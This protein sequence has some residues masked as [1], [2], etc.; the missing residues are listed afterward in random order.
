MSKLKDISSIK[1]ELMSP[2]RI[3]ELSHGE[4][5]KPE[6]I[7]YRT[8]KPERDGLFCE[9]IFGTT[10][11]W[12][13]SCGKYKGQRYKGVVCDRCG[14]EV[15][16]F[17]VRRERMGHIELAAPVAHTWYYNNVPS[18]LGMLLNL[19]SNNVKSILYFERLVVM[20]VRENVAKKIDPFFLPFLR[21]EI[22]ILDAFTEDEFN[23]ILKNMIAEFFIK[24]YSAEYEKSLKE[25]EDNAKEARK[26]ILNAHIEEYYELMDQLVNDLNKEDDDRRETAIRVGMGGKA[27]KELLTSLDLKKMAVDMRLIMREKGKKTDKRIV[28]MLEMTEHFLR[29]SSKPEW[30]ILDVLPVI[31]PELRPMVELDGGR[32]ATSDLNDLYRR[33]INRN[34]RLKRLVSLRAPGIII[35]NEKRMLQEA[36]DSLLDNSKRKKVE[37]KSGNRP[38]KSLSDMLRGKQGRFRQNLLGKRVDYSGRSVI[39]V[40]PELKLHQCGLPKK[41]AI[42][43]FKPFIIGEL[44]KRDENMHIKI[45]KTKI[46]RGDLDVMEVLEKVVRHHP[47]FL[48]RAPTLHRLGIQAFE[49]ILIDGKAIRLHPLVCRAF[50]ADFDGDQMAVHVPLS[51]EAQIEAWNLMLS[52]NNILLPANGKPVVVPSQDIVLGINYLTK[53]KPG[54]PGEGKRFAEGR[55]AILA[56][57]N[58]AIELQSRIYIR[59]VPEKQAKNLET[60]VGRYLFNLILPYDTEFLNEAVNVKKLSKIIADINHRYTTAITVE[61]LD[62]VKETGFKYAT[63]FAP[64]IGIED[65]VIPKDKYKIVDET[66]KEVNNINKNHLRGFLTN[67]ERAN[68]VIDCWNDANERI[69]DVMFRRMQEDRNGFNPVYMM[70]ES[71]ARGSKLQIRQLAGMRGLMAK[72]SGE[73]IELPITSNFREGLTVL[74]YFISTHGARKGLS[75]TALKTADAGYLTRRLVDVSHNIM[76]VEED[77]RTINGI[78][79]TAIRD[80][81]EELKSL[82]D[83]IVGRISLENIYHSGSGDVIVKANDE[84]T[85]EIADAIERTGIDRVRIRSVLTCETRNGVCCKCYGRNLA[86]NKSVEIGEAIGII[87]AQSIGQPGTQLTMRTFH[88]GGTASAEKSNRYIKVKNAVYITRM[89]T[90]T[91]KTT[92]GKTIVSRREELIIQNVLHSWDKK[93]V[94]SI[95][96]DLNKKNQPGAILLKAKQGGF[97]VNKVSYLKLIDG[98][99]VLLGEK[100]DF[101]LKIGTVMFCEQDQLVT[102]SKEEGEKILAEFDPFNETIITEHSGTIKFKDIIP[103]ETLKE[104]KEENSDN[105]NYVV[106]KSKSKSEQYQPRVTVIRDDH[107][108]EENYIIPYGSILN[109]KDGDHVPSAA[110]LVKIPETLSKTKDITGGLPRV[111]ELFEARRPK[112]C[113]VLTEIDGEAE[114][115]AIVKGK[116]EIV[117]KDEHGGTK[118][119]LI[120]LGKML[121]IQDGDFVRAGDPLD[122]G[123]I[124]P[125]DILKIRGEQELQQYLI[126]EIQEVYLLQDVDINDKHIEVMIKQM[127]SKIEITEVGD[128]SF[129]IGEFVDRFLFRDENQR[130]MKEGGKPAMGRVALLGITK[131]SLNTDSFLS[132]A[133]FQETTKVLTEAAIRGRADRLEGLKENIII[134]NLIPAGSGSRKYNL[135]IDVIV[136]LPPPPPENPPAETAVEPVAVAAETKE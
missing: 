94:K 103:G 32:F 52:A 104:D 74:E 86:N 118:K 26:A 91:V 125:H 120:P 113:A 90:K 39:I 57:E 96:V 98:Q 61:M 21:D 72:P 55:E 50:N 100:K 132:A 17:K 53:I 8:L 87:A 13:C 121:T 62:R 2:E 131:A 88:I 128:T 70:A 101:R 84:I 41:M 80:G 109:V 6:T 27:I 10:K 82:K 95:E 111:A 126:N 136:D 45:A 81:E 124:D 108:G 14:V 28:K 117:V 46:E 48:N 25:G 16:H 43:L 5:K 92:E 73:I 102:P 18:R 34:N 31:P 19:S 78:T 105:I 123:P 54:E 12:E 15:S 40:G 20:D 66:Q 47:V 115:G 67:K 130:V 1:I 110:R 36:V 29:S 99:Y 58:G 30:M 38:L 133:S 11:E 76:V 64:S 79:I 93:D 59:S 127:L 24:K 60:S 75:D 116:R 7:N 9:R 22:H 23:I 68:Q 42:E 37:K 3:R 49:P 107:R 65:I 112:D 89:P 63:L 122:V 85:E 51:V 4:V 35:R 134:G 83:R 77:C 44:M 56:Y 33:V 69:T 71:G 106:V 135:N 129:L 114:F 97:S 119:Y